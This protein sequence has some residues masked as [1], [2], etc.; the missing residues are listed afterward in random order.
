MKKKL[1]LML[2]MALFTVGS[3]FAQRTI[4]GSV[5]DDKGEPMVGASVVAKGTTTGIITDVDGNFKLEVPKDASVLSVSFVGYNNLE[6]P[7]TGS[8]YSEAEYDNTP[9]NGRN[10]YSP[11]A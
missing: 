10:P 9:Q 1:L 8:Q 11:L 5:K 3:I 2:S 4:V 6:V 7:I